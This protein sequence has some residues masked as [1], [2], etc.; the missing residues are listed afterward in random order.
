MSA[1][2]LRRY[3]EAR[4]LYTGDRTRACGKYNMTQTVTKIH[5]QDR[6]HNLIIH[7]IRGDK[8]MVTTAW[9]IVQKTKKYKGSNQTFLTSMLCLQSRLHSL[10]LELFERPVMTRPNTRQ[11]AAPIFRLHLASVP[12]T[13]DPLFPRS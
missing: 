1:N 9:H 4:R 8:T 7:M 13:S 10:C 11:R 12:A 2:T 3:M 5:P 6:S